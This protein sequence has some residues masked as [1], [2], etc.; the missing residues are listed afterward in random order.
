MK[1]EFE[2][3]IPEGLMRLGYLECLSFLVLLFIAMPLKYFW[4]SPAAVQVVGMLHGILFLIY[5]GGATIWF[6]KAKPPLKSLLFIYLASVI[7]FGPVF[8]DKRLALFGPK[9]FGSGKWIR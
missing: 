5:V 9:A 4:D 2:K 6:V 7:P 3:G 8:L 1:F